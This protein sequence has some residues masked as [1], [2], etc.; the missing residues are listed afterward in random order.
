MN[1]KYIV[2][3]TNSNLGTYKLDDHGN[4]LTKIN[5]IYV[6]PNMVL[7]LGHSTIKFIDAKGEVYDSKKL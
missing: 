1:D 4:R 5:R 2:A 6:K 7:G 3:D